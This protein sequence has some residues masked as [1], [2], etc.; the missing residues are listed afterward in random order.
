MIKGSKAIR[1]DMCSKKIGWTIPTGNYHHG[2]K[3][4]RIELSK[5]AMEVVSGFAVH[6][7]C[8]GCTR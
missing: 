8:R 3:E 1:C 2:I 4:V 7:R 5:E 6:Y